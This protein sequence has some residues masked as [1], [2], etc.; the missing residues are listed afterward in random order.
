[1]PLSLNLTKRDNNETLDYYSSSSP[2]QGGSFRPRSFRTK[3]PMGF[4][5]RAGCA[6]RGT[7]L[8]GSVGAFGVCTGGADGRGIPSSGSVYSGGVPTS[9]IASKLSSV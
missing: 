1:M 8:G 4:G 2:G 6:A 9:S 5:T 7:L 3:P